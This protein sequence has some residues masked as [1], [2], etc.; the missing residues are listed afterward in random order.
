MC[1]I[2]NRFAKLTNN[3]LLTL[4]FYHLELILN[5]Y[6]HQQLVTLYLENHNKVIVGFGRVKMR[7]VAKRN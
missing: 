2:F 1:Y 7:V 6:L 3:S 4:C 5:Q